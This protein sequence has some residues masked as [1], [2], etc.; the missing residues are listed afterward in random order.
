MKKLDMKPEEYIE[1]GSLEADY[2]NR[3]SPVKPFQGYG[4]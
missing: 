2:V 3:T 4:Q 1:K